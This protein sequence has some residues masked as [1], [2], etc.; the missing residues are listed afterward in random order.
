[1]IICHLTVP[2]H[3]T[4]LKIAPS[5]LAIN[6]LTTEA[7]QFIRIFNEENDSTQQVIFLHV[8]TFPKPLNV[9]GSHPSKN[10]SDKRQPTQRQTYA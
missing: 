2:T 5:V 8:N 7:V 9:Q 10:N 1:M 4:P 6:Q 3:V